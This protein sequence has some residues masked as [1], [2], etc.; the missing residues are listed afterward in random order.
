[1]V[2]VLPEGLR[3]PDEDVQIWMP[4]G[5]LRDESYM[6]NRAVHV[7]LPVGRLRANVSL[8]EARAELKAWTDTLRAREPATDP[9]HSLL[10]RSLAAQVSANA[11]PAL[12]ALASAV[13][14]L[15]VVTCCS[16]GL[17]LLTRGA[18]RST[19]V[20]LRLSL[21]ASRARLVRQL[22]TEALCLAAIGGAAGFAG[23]HLL[24]A[25][26]VRGRTGALPPHVVPSI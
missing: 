3:F 8:D 25:F 18:D 4:I 21:G 5:Q 6:R 26:L 13:L 24:L 20:A 2:G 12:V 7:T 22:V 19:E 23:A 14:L 17:L 1:M 15:L 10:V 11:R 9:G 16:V